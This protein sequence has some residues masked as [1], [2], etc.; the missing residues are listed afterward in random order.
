MRHFSF[1]SQKGERPASV[2]YTF[3][4][5]GSFVANR[6]A[7]KYK[8]LDLRFPSPYVCK[9]E[10]LSGALV[11]DRNGSWQLAP[12]LVDEAAKKEAEA[13]LAQVMPTIKEMMPAAE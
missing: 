6:H 5:N 3:L 9:I 1:A 7:V 8:A 2:F 13:F 10:V 12:D 11:K 4:T